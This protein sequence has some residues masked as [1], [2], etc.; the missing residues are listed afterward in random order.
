GMATLA[1]FELA[2]ERIAVALD[3]G[4]QEDEHSCFSDN[5]HRDFVTNIVG[6]R[7]VYLGKYGKIDGTGIHGILL[8]SDPERAAKLK[9]NIDAVVVQAEAL[10]PPIDRILATPAGD[11]ARA[12]MEQLVKQLYSQA[13][14]LLDASKTIGVE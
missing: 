12:P 9:A 8:A 2:S 6:I 13:E 10:T 14:L 3:S 4:D 11:P 1:G 7:N 5:T